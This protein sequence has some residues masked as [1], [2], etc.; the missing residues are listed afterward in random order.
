MPHPE[1]SRVP[2]L[3]NLAGFRQALRLDDRSFGND[4]STT[5]RRHPRARWRSDGMRRVEW[6]LPEREVARPGS[7]RPSI[8]NADA[9]GA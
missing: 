1:A 7:R 8:R 9:L 6:P 2:R 4:Y 3:R 5:R